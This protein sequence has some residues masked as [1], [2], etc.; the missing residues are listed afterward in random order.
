[1]VGRVGDSSMSSSVPSHTLLHYCI[2]TCPLTIGSVHRARRQALYLSFSAFAR[3]TPYTP[4]PVGDA[5]MG[6]RWTPVS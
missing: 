5:L 4:Y 1:M 2:Y 3:M 6:A